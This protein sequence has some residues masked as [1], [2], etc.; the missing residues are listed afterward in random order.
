L[1]VIFVLKATHHAGGLSRDHIVAGCG[2]VRVEDS[3][4]NR[5]LPA[6]DRRHEV[7]SWR[8]ADF[9][10]DGS[11]HCN[12]IESI[13]L[14]NKSRRFWFGILRVTGRSP[15]VSSFGFSSLQRPM[16]LPQAWPC[17][18][19]INGTILSPHVTAL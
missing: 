19:R 11:L 4:S 10:I 2:A 12:L 15:S 18:G 1:A 5:L 7:S 8:Q 6:S 3:E 9:A 13:L 17:G 16:L 14:T